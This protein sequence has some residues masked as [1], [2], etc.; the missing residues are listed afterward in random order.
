LGLRFGLAICFPNLFHPDEIF[1]TLEPAHRLAYGYGVVTWEWLDGVRSWVFPAFLA[2]V[3]R[4]TDWAGPGSSGYLW[5]TTVVLSLISL[6]T[7]WFGYAWA[8]RASGTQAAIIAA[9]ACSIYFGLVYFAPKALNEVVAT[10][11]LLPGLYLGV[12][13]EKIG[14]KKRLFLAGLLCGLAAMLRIQLLPSVFFAVAY[15]CYPYW[16]RRIPVVLAGLSL[17]VLAFGLVDNVTWSYPWQSSIRYFQVNLIAGR[18][19]GFEHMPWYWYLRALLILIGPAVLLLWH[20]ARKSPFLAYF[21]LAVVGS[22]SLIAHKEIRFIYPVLP[23]ALTLAS[24][25]AVEVVSDWKAR[26]KRT[27]SPKSTIAFGLV[28]FILSSI[29]I[30]ILCH[31]WYRTNGGI[32]AMDRLSQDSALCGV[33]IY[34]FYWWHSGGYVHLHRNVPM[35]PITSSAQLL[36]D[37]PSFNAL[38]APQHISGIPTAFKTSECWNDVCLLQREGGCVPPPPG[39][40][41]NTIQRAENGNPQ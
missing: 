11:L 4:A 7:I 30:F 32:A 13:A 9:G 17:P 15:F 24:I 16:R 6:S 25:G 2:G 3:M 36:R 39:D 18:G 33:G 41:I 10:H 27:I 22:H 38:L 20:G 35:M 23:V 21:A 14:E 31:K 5:G 28:F 19:L 26:T 8:R 1:Q 34:Q 40:E 37:A 29:S 12:Y